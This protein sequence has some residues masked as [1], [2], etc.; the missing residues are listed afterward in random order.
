MKI[1]MGAYKLKDLDRAMT[2]EI[3]AKNVETA[4]GVWYCQCGSQKVR[5]DATDKGTFDV[6]YAK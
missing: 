4:N 2:V 1:S 5:R 3:F 6:C